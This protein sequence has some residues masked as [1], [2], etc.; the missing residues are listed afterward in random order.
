MKKCPYCA[1][2]IQDEAIKC[3]HCGSSLYEKKIEEDQTVSSINSERYKKIVGWIGKGSLA[4][5]AIVIWYISIP[6]ILI[7]YI[8]KKQSGI[9]RKKLLEQF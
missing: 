1:E 7:W 2:D 6:L 8:W 5:L 4:I 3:K 9:K